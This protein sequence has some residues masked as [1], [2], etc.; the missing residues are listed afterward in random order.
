MP[1]FSFNCP[2]CKEKIR[3]ILPIAPVEPFPCPKCESTLERGSAAPT[4]RV[5][6]VRDNGIMP[7]QVEQLVD[8]GDMIKERSTDP[9]DPDIV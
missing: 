8:I 6:E 1:L 9:E 3:R 7:R 5:I 4:S 2:T